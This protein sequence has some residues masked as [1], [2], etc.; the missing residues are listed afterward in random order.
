MLQKDARPETR[1]S[2]KLHEIARDVSP[3]GVHG[4][5]RWYEP[6]PLYFARAAGARLWDV[7]GNEY[8]DLHGGLGPYVLG[9]NHPEVLAAAVET[10]TR[11]GPHLGLPHPGEVQLCRALVDLIPCAEKVALCGGGGSDP[12]YHAIRL[13][14]AYTG[15]R[16]IIKFEGGQNGWAEPLSMSI[17]PS[18]DEVGPYE[19]PNSVASP[20]ILPEVVANTVV[21]P[22]N[23]T[24]R[25]E[26]AWRANSLADVASLG[27]PVKTTPTLGNW[28]TRRRASWT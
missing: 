15:R 7:D 26:P 10:L 9:Y 22:A 27:A 23:E 1:Q 2:E 4:S 28:A 3:L 21:L 20:G 17:T 16:K 12:C 8:I 18:A 14:R 5:G 25:S 13:A 24:Q 6:W 19:R 11:Q